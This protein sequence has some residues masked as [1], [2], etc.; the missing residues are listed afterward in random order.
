MKNKEIIQNSLIVQQY[1]NN[2]DKSIYIENLNDG[3]ILKDKDTKMSFKLR[4]D[5]YSKLITEK[6]K[7]IFKKIFKGTNLKILDC[8]GGFGKD[9]FLLAS[10]GHQVTFLE[11]NPIV[12]V[13]IQDAI[14][15]I[16]TNILQESCD[17]ITF[18]FGN[19]LDYIRHNN[20]AF[21]Y[22]YFDFMF[23]VNSTALPSKREQF[24]RRLVNNNPTRNI[25]IIKESIERLSS[26]IIIKEHI[27]SSD[28]EA[29]DIVHCYK[30]RVV[31]YNLIN[32]NDS[33]K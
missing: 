12:M 28:Y 25:R 22:V 13:M 3:I 20:K 11:E 5:D 8:T 27:K 4:L 24:L 2:F 26:K 6:N 19:C 16:G 7:H 10:L 32:T 23:N 33:S 18:L 30:E 21:D 9:S 14:K 15:H 17:R 31:K 29:L 1:F